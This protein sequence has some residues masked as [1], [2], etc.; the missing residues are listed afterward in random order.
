MAYTL[1]KL[2]SDLQAKLSKDAGP[3]GQQQCLEDVSRALLDD[4]F[5]AK[6]LKPEDCK[7]RKVLFEDPDL[8][9]CICGHVYADGMKKANPHDHGPTW[10]IYGLADGTTD[11]TDWEIT[12]P[13]DGDNP[14]MVKP[15]R[16]YQL[17]RGDCHLY[18]TGD[19]HSPIMSEGTR[20]IRVEGKNL[21]TIQRSNIKAA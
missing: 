4:E 8:G 16:T 10:A 5:V 19:V 12:T 15:T 6:H 9:F 11:M 14:S 1:E 21:D 3:T 13:A 18:K 2:A 20:L 17:K 7:P